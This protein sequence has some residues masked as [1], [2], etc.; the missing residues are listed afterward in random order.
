M[1]KKNE[2]CSICEEYIDGVDC[3]LDGCPVFEMK[4]ENK[5]LKK[6][7]SSLRGK[8]RSMESAASWDEEIRR[9]QVQGMW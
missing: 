2:P 8:I 6:T 7:V 5:K 4:E 9:G 3:A 1:A